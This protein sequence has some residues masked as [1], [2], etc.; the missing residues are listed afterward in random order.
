MYN[1]IWSIVGGSSGCYSKT[2]STRKAT[3]TTIGVTP[4]AEGCTGLVFSASNSSTIYGSSNT[5]T[6]L[7]IKVKYLIKY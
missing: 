4:P 3:H 1:D 5:V 7:S 6:P 2:S